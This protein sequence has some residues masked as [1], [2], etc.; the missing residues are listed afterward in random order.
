MI[1]LAVSEFSGAMSRSSYR[2]VGA[3]HSQRARQLDSR[4]LAAR[5]IRGW[6]RH[7]TELGSGRVN[8]FHLARPGTAPLPDQ[9]QLATILRTNLYPEVTDRVCRP[10]LPTSFYRLEAIHLGKLLRIW[11]R[12]GAVFPVALAWV[13]KVQG[14]DS[15]TAVNAV[16][17]TFQP[18][19]PPRGFQRTRTLIEKRQLSPD[20]PTASS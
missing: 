13:F 20:L 14:E 3:D 15:D 16:L 4:R 10:S 5:K 19:L 2:G 7:G 6:P 1:P 9:A 18:Y 17:F 8:S 11:I 12:A